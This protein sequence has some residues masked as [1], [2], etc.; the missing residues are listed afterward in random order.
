MHFSPTL[1]HPLFKLFSLVEFI[2]QPCVTGRLDL[3]QKVIRITPCSVT[4]EIVMKI[5]SLFLLTALVLPVTP[6]LVSAQGAPAIPMVVCH[7]DKAPQMLVP[8]YVC[9]WYGGRQHY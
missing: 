5:K 1:P 2:S 9:Q 6:S 3:T 4:K 7:V 8:E